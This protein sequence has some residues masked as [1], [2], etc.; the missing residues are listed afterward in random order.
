ML[1]SGFSNHLEP[2]SAEVSKQIASTQSDAARHAL[3]YGRFEELV[4]EA[5]G[6]V[7]NVQRVI[8]SCYDQLGNPVAG[9]NFDYYVNT[10][11]NIFSSYS[12]VRDRDLKPIMQHDLQVFQ[13]EAKEINAESASRNFIKQ[14]YER[15]YNESDLFTK[16]FSIEPRFSVDGRS[17]Y[18]A[19]K[20]QQKALV[21]A[22]NVAPI[23]NTLQPVLH[24]S[25]LQTICNLLGWLT[26]EYLLLDYD[27]DISRYSQ[28]C[29]ELTA[30]LLMEH[31]WPFTDT[32]FQNEI[33]KSIT[34]H[35]IGPDTL[36]ITSVANGIA[37]SNAHPIAKKALELLV[38]YDQAMPKERSVS[39]CP[40]D[41][42]FSA[43]DKHQQQ[44]SPVIFKIVKETILA[45]Q[46]AEA[47]IKSSKSEQPDPDL[48]MIKNLLIV[49][50]ELVSL[51]IGD[52]RSQAAANMQHFGQIWDTLSPQNWMGLF[53]GILGG[54]LNLGLWSSAP[55][56]IHGK[57]ANTNGGVQDASG[58]LDE[59]LRQS[60]Y[61]FTQRWGGLVNAARNGKRS[62]KTLVQIEK[63]LD[64][65]LLTAFGGQPEVVGK[66]KE[67]IHMNAQAQK[68]IGG[69]KR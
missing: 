49:K 63:E 8:R 57:P 40:T 4:L 17:A 13:K 10:A 69:T 41:F 45:L 36:K 48:F 39:Y 24:T 64:E 6:L 46:K 61:A 51:E 58:R 35:P 42:T 30:R 16:I 29:Q 67:A 26:N 66:L 21:N 12:G 11:V 23:A 47:R 19:L 15:S 62:P 31:L 32:A 56:V 33:N 20:S 52:V 2:I 28:H 43:T 38:M 27:E 18:A 5:D 1:E 54:S 60:I 68:E 50:N 3:A 34:R 65:K 22:A 55:S 9:Q 25:E 14:C 59:L 44:S 37:S 7:S 53:R